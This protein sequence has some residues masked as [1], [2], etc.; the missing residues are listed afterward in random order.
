M[1]PAEQLKHRSKQCA[2][3]IVKLFG[4]SRVQKRRGSSES[5]SYVPEPLLRRIIAPCAELARRLNS[6]PRYELSSK[7][8]M[9]QRFGWSY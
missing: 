1:H 8:L 2:I 3:R 4:P 6:L 7:R 9:R 5:K